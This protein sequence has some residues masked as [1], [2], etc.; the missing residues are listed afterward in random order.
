MKRWQTFVAL[1]GHLRAGLLGGAPPAAATDIHWKLLIEASSY[2]Y[3]TPALAWCLRDRTGM[4]SD[5]ADF[6]EATLTLNGRRNERLSG[7]LARVAA[8]LNAIDIEPVLLKG[9]A[10]LA[11]GAYP[12]A[13]LRFLGDLDLLIPGDRSAD[14][15]SAL[16]RAGFERVSH[17]KSND[18]HHHLPVLRERE[19]GACV[20]LH[21][22]LSMPPHDAIIP[23]DWFRQGTRA[24]TWR[25]RRVRLPDATRSVVHN[26][27]HDQLNHQNYRAG[28]AELRQLLDLAML[29]AR[30]EASI[31][32]TELDRRFCAAGQGPLLATY[33]E[34]ASVLFGQSAPP[35]LSHPPRPGAMADF[36][37]DVEWPAI[38]ILNRLRIPVDYVLARRG[39]PLS[40]LK[41]LT[42]RQTWSA[43]AELVRSAF[44]NAKW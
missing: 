31:D 30:H 25:D 38:R 15:A 4:P 2:H 18:A 21:T 1:S 33:L 27:V 23:A 35:G 44:A 34:F 32:W 37:R 7:A 42:R 13:A 24:L 40:I 29:R 41:R 17:I 28:R 20:E 14:A 11:E 16:R 5:V 36:R 43:A 19:S 8:A 39:D 3:V 6:F 10:R 22:G 12:A 26:I 9:A